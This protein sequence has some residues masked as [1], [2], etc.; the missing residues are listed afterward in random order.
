MLGPV[1]LDTSAGCS[2]SDGWSLELR[3]MYMQ[4]SWIGSQVVEVSLIASC[5]R[6][7]LRWRARLTWIPGALAREEDE[8]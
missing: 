1:L 3:Q 7:L 6:V 8:R 2:R 5:Q 4:C